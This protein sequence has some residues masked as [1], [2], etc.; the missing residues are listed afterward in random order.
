MQIMCVF[1][2]GARGLN[3]YELVNRNVTACV[4][5]PVLCT[6]DSGLWM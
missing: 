1:L 6:V 3:F 4:Y 2:R 5:M